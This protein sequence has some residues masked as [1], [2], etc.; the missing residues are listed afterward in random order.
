MAEKKQAPLGKSTK[1]F[2]SSTCIIVHGRKNTEETNTLDPWQIFSR[3]GKILQ[4]EF[5]TMGRIR[6]NQTNF[7]QTT[8]CFQRIDR[9]QLLGPKENN[10]DLCLDDIESIYETSFQSPF[11]DSQEIES[12]TNVSYMNYIYIPEINN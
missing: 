2:C 1:F 12:R 7:K 6:R 11:R 4:T 9:G 5:R 10:T 8:E 3:Y